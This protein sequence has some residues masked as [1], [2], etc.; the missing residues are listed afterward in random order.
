MRPSRS[1]TP[2]PS[3]SALFERV[4]AATGADFAGDAFV[5]P[6]TSHTQLYM[7]RC[8]RLRSRGYLPFRGNPRF[9]VWR[10]Q[11][12]REFLRLP[13][14]PPGGE[15]H[16]RPH[17]RHGKRALWKRRPIATH[18]T[19]GRGQRD[20]INTNRTWHHRSSGQRTPCSSSDG[21]TL[22]GRA[23]RGQTCFRRMRRSHS[24]VNCYSGHQGD[25][26]W[27]TTS[28]RAMGSDPQGLTPACY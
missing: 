28:G 1:A 8:G 3:C 5:A 10:R 21:E 24:K 14:L 17:P 2:P 26:F 18:A 19:T 13:P 15:G 11:R 25:R 22:G 20:P 6:E 4:A 9:A 23:Q 7:A 16:R 12:W 27:R